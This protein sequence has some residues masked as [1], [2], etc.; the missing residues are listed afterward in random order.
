MWSSLLLTILLTTGLPEDPATRVHQVLVKLKEPKKN[1]RSERFVFTG[2][3]LNAFADAV[4]QGEKRLGVEKLR[5]GL[6]QDGFS[7]RA[8]I[9]MDEVQLSGIAF[10]MFRAVMSGMQT[11]E[12]EGKFTTANGKGVCKITSSSF[13]NLPVPAW[14]VNAVI[15]YLG[16]RQ[17]PHIDISEPFD[18]PYGIRDVKL[19]P[20]KLVLIR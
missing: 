7:A 13:N 9:N 2:E 6:K 18:L 17:P 16:K 8:V 4:I 5:L 19:I 10:R 20:D 3:E 15:G 12:A 14:L 11:L 1:K